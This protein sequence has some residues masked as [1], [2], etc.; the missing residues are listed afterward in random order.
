MLEDD[1]VRYIIVMYVPHITREG[2]TQW[3]LTSND[4]R[5]IVVYMPDFPFGVLD[6]S[7]IQV[8]IPIYASGSIML[9][10]FILRS[11]LCTRIMQNVQK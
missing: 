3:C 6:S 1:N 4:T 7:G 9:Q 11:D 8:L 10:G 5:I 2:N